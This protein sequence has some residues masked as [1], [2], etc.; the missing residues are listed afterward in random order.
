MKRY[1]GA[2]GNEPDDSYEFG[3]RGANE[4]PAQQFRGPVHC[5]DLAN[6]GMLYVCDRQSNRIQVFTREGEF[7]K[8]GFFARKAWAKGPSGTSPSRGIRSS[9]T[10]T[11]PTAA[12]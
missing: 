4:P 6:D 11:S 1:W 10:S 8:E 3:P 9:G 12:T 2:Y 7:V 5:A